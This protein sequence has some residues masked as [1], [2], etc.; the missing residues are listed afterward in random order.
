M[1]TLSFYAHFAIG[2]GIH[3]HHVARKLYGHIL[4]WQTGFESGNNR[5]CQYL[6]S[7]IGAL[8]FAQQAHFGM[9]KSL[10]AVLTH[11]EIIQH[12]YA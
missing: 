7:H 5:V 10:V 11:N 3:N 8:W 9:H 12:T 6:L 4:C 1:A 2:R